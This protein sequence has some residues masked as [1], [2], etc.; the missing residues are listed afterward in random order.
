MKLSATVMFLC[1]CGLLALGL[2]ILY[3]LGMAKEGASYLARQTLWCGV[4]MVVCLGVSAIDYRHL[5]KVSMLMYV[6]ALV[7][8]AMV[9]VWGVGL[10]SNGARRWLRYGSVG[11]QPSEFAKITLII[12][13]AHYGEHFQRQMG[14]FRRGVLPASAVI[15]SMLALIFLEPDRGTTVFLG[16]ISLIMLVLAGV[17]WLV[18]ILPASLGAA[19]LG[20]LL[21]RDPLIISRVTKGWWN[22]ELH[23]TGPAYQSWQ[24]LIAF[25]AGGPTGLGLGDG[26][27][28]MGFIPELQTD[29]ILPVV[30]EE[31]GL[32]ATAAVVITFL[33]FVICGFRIARHA[34]D[35]FGFLLASGLTCL[36]GM[37]AWINIAVVT[38]IL[39]NKGLSL[40]FV[41]YG[42]S[43]L[44]MM[45]F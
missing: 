27:Q 41:S 13:L 23:K 45:L 19:G 12:V 17:R 44:V 24:G 5:K 8:L 7:L 6:A 18:I 10:T 4:G 11:F 34:P 3:S 39:P 29:F 26:R 1:V 42:G 21:W 15:G 20:F 33:V 2:V 40:P 35:L 16:G 31:L 25:G 37:Q 36:I 30:G 43:N 32:V 14:S 38:S 28:K 9:L 22:M